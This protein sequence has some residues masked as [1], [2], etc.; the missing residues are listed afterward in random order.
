MKNVKIGT[1]ALMSSLVG[2]V[3]SGRFA[4]A[5]RINGGGMCEL[6]LAKE[7]KHGGSRVAVKILRPKWMGHAD[8]RG[9]I[10]QEVEVLSRLRGAGT[11]AVVALIDS[12]ERPRPFL[13]T[14]YYDCPNLRALVNVQYRRRFDVSTAVG[15]AWQ[16]ASALRAAHAV[17]VVHRDLKPENTLTE[18]NQTVAGNYRIILCDFGIAR[19]HHA[20]RSPNTA[21]RWGTPAYLAPEERVVSIPTNQDSTVER[22]NP[23][24]DVYSLGIMAYE[25]LTGRRPFE[26]SDDAKLERM[27]REDPPDIGALIDAGV[28]N[29]VIE[30]VLRMLN[31]N[32][33]ERPKAEEIESS[34]RR[35][36]HMSTVSSRRQPA[37][38]PPASRRLAPVLSNGRSHDFLHRGINRAASSPRSRARLIVIAAAVGLLCPLILSRRVRGLFSS[39]RPPSMTGAASPNLR[40]T[41]SQQPAAELGSVPPPAIGAP[42]SIAH[43]LPSTGRGS[44]SETRS[45]NRGGRSLLDPR[46]QIRAN[47]NPEPNAPS[48]PV[49]TESSAR[50]PLWRI[51]EDKDGP[52]DPFAD[53]EKNGPID[54]FADD[55]KDLREV[56]ACEWRNGIADHSED[57]KSSS[58]KELH[59]ALRPSADGAACL[60]PLPTTESAARNQTSSAK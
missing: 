9:C 52:I 14:P 54:P 53:D 35:F 24:R 8:A 51:P 36:A 44:A 20:V 27:H 18:P 49:H 12:G 7:L 28:P 19:I 45:W 15:I 48:S 55:E 56:A 38:V 23:A 11:T 39:R 57:L 60:Q 59:E 10:M 16:I 34:F 46:R 43:R 1:R 32:P 30:Y 21:L 25:L 22:L 29:D 41:Q 26:D 37:T 58:T 17:G 2:T 6:W 31:K 40:V 47:V 4:L 13:V 33:D 3:L 50:H 5:N 42:Q